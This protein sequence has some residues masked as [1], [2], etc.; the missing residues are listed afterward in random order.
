MARKSRKPAVVTEEPAVLE[1]V[2]IY[3]GIYT[4][5]SCKATANRES[6]S[7]LHQR[8]LC[9]EYL[10]DKPD[11]TLVDTYMDNGFTGTNFERLEFQRMIC[12]IQA[13][14]INCVVVKD[15]SRFGRN[16]LEVDQYLNVRFPEWKV[17]FIAVLD[18]FDTAVPN[19]DSYLIIPFRN[20]LNEYYS[21]DFS[22]KVKSAF[23]ARMKNGVFVRNAVNT[24]YGYIRDGENHT[25]RIDPDTA[26]VLQRMFQMRY[27]GYSY[28]RISTI[29]NQ[30]GI[31]SPARY[32]YLKGLAYNSRSEH[33]V[34]T[35]GAV[36]V[37]MSNQ[38]YLGT[39]IH[40]KT[41]TGLKGSWKRD[42]PREQQ[43]W[44]ENAHEPLVTQEVFDKVQALNQ[45]VK[46]KHLSLQSGL[47]MICDYREG[48]NSRIFCGD[49]G[50]RIYFCLSKY[51]RG[52]KVAYTRCHSYLR[53]RGTCSIHSISMPKL[54]E[55]IDH[56]L[57]QQVSLASIV[58]NAYREMI[59]S[60]TG[61]LSQLKRKKKSLVVRK[62]NLSERKS[63][64]LRDYMAKT[65]NRKEHFILKEQYE[66][67][68]AQLE[69][70]LVA[71]QREISEIQSLAGSA[72]TWVKTL[73]GY[74]QNQTITNE[75]IRE[76][77]ERVDLYQNGKT[78]EVKLT[79]R[80]QNVFQQF[81]KE[82]ENHD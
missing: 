40:H 36:R 77:V 41:E 48:L 73:R 32:L 82:T 39:R 38:V 45:S 49:C 13:K 23:L 3:V 17:R 4:R 65:L 24:P 71:V 80:F 53:Y 70:E 57:K 33:S 22:Q 51:G 81:M 55:I 52:T 72:K 63:Q 11:M 56:A 7:L 27:E 1:K 21:R 64:L 74:D 78:V 50:K 2:K 76:L 43:I 54:V 30:E 34:W 58:E 26:P 68:S 6:D 19:K 12:D 62:G 67:Q 25:F 31:P 61:K 9:M 66:A 20:I 59:L 47:T 14:R 8:E 60:K 75:M 15:L 5:L 18:H 35:S 29:L 16:Y 79:F 42:V 46:E 10:K 37:I 28:Y 69:E 44:F